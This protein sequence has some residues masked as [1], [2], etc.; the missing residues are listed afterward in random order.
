M[1]KYT[2]QDEKTGKKITFDWS[3]EGEPTDKDM[4]DIFSAAG[5]QNPVMEKMKDRAAVGQRLSNMIGN[6]PQSLGNLLKNAVQGTYQ[7]VRHPINTLDNLM[8]SAAKNVI[9]PG[10]GAIEKVTGLGDQAAVKDYEDAKR[11]FS[12]SRYGSLEN[13]ANYMEKDPAMAQSDLAMALTAGGGVLKKAGSLSKLPALEKA[14]SVVS[15]VG[16]MAEP[17]TAPIKAAGTGL[18][19]MM[20]SRAAQ[21]MYASSAKMSTVMDPEVRQ[22]LSQKLLD[23]EVTLNNKGFTKLAN[24]FESL[25]RGVDDMVDQYVT[26]GANKKTTVV[27]LLKGVDDWEKRASLTGRQDLV[28]NIKN[29]MIRGNTEVIMVGKKPVR[30]LK[31]LDAK[32]VNRLKRDIYQE[33]H[34]QYGKEMVPMAAAVKMHIAHNAMDALETMIPGIVPNNKTA[35]AYKEMM[36]VIQKGVN[37]IENRDLFSI[38]MPVRAGGTAVLSE[39]LGVDTKVGGLAGLALG[40]LDIPSVKSRVAIRLNKL[41]R[42]GVRLS[43]T[44]TAIKY[45]LVKEGEQ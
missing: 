38:G 17:I 23:A 6:Y 16:A 35:A 32:Q 13:F 1:P 10:L 40:V 43:P 19:F 18:Q 29:K 4:E 28:R 9:A 39:A 11:R 22:R 15:G 42:E 33:L 27:D 41:K 7:T 8:I 44:A 20:P 21:K 26:T 12:E 3:G 30:I 24:D 45:G 36:D 37:R 5:Q 2:V 25:W 14:G 34:S 31:E